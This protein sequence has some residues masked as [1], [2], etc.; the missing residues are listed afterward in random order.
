MTTITNRLQQIQSSLTPKMPGKYLT[1]FQD[2]SVLLVGG[3]SGI[4]FGIAEASIEFGASV[5]V[6]S[7]TQ[8]NVDKAV[9]R[10]KASYPDAKSKIRG[11]TVDLGANDVEA[12]L[13]K[14]FDFATNTGSDKL[15]HVVDTAGDLSMA[16]R[17]NLQT[18]TPDLMAEANK[19]RLVGSIM[20]AKYTNKYL[21][22]AYTSSFTMTSGALA[23]RPQ[24]GY[25]IM[26]GAG[27]GKDSLTRGLAKD[28]APIRVNLVSPGAIETE[29]LY[30]L[31]PG[32]KN[33]A[34]V[35]RFQS[36]SILKRIGDVEDT[37]EVYMMI[38]KSNFV[39]GT[40]M[41]VEGGYLLS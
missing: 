38:M 2:K 39:T 37:T 35:E 40:V 24:A 19:V 3:T 4:G 29:L 15:D 8:A 16:G 36:M 27:G 41:H 25:G 17:L 23:Y 18:V 33:D 7:R 13:Q 26:L 28:M 32:G 1:K 30:R 34:M 5:V 20:L 14:L 11:H 21:N 10:L 22:K 6:A 12:Q 31:A 9:E